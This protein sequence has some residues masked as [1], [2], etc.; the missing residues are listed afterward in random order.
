[1]AKPMPA[2]AP[3]L[4]KNRCVHP[5]HPSRRIQERP[6]GVAGIDRG[7]GLDHVGDFG[8]HVLRQAP[9]Q[10]ADQARGERL[11]QPV[12]VADREHRLPDEQVVGVSNVQRTQRST[13]RLQPQHREIIGRRRADQPRRNQTAIGQ[14]DAER[15]APGDDV[16]IGDDVP[17]HIPDHAGPGLECD[18]PA[19]RYRRRGGSRIDMHDRGRIQAEHVDRC[20]FRRV[21]AAT[22]RHGARQRRRPPGLDDVGRDHPDRHQQKQPDERDPQQAGCHA[23]SVSIRAGTVKLTGRHRTV[24]GPPLTPTLSQGRGGSDCHRSWRC[25]PSPACGRELG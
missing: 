13:G 22:R 16:I 7:V 6:P 18:L 1:M 20:L 21:Q 14:P 25:A 19:G 2:E 5:D 11:V 24:F 10:R 9:V 23:S 12:R 8:L 3:E 15:D 4:R 17:R